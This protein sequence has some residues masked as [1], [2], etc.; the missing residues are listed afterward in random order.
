M[1]FPGTSLPGVLHTYTKYLVA[2]E[3]TKSNASPKKIQNTL[4]FIGGLMDGLFTV[5]YATP[6]AEAMPPSWSV[7]SVLLSSSYRQW[8]IASLDSD[9]SELASCVSYFRKLRPNGKIVLMGHSTGCQDVMHYLV[10]LESEDTSLEDSKNL[11]GGSCSVLARPK[12]DGGIMQASVSDRE[13]LIMLLPS[14]QYEASVKIAQVYISQNRGED[15]LPS[16]ATAGFLNVPVSARR[17]LSLA[18]PGPDHAG[19]D[20]FFSSDLPDSRIKETFG[21]MSH[22]GDVRISILMSGED[23]FV[24]KEVDKKTMVSKWEAAVKAGEGLLD[25]DSGIVEG[26]NH[27]LDG[28]PEHVTEDLVRRVIGFVERV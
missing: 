18:S 15:I 23:Q 4:I 9:V 21:K 11:T 13:A 19:E 8:G 20:D 5:P 24:P 17:W 10:S 27:N 12:I 7:V 6:L 16:W 22:G 1:A 26:A 28:V 3:P 25:E 2:F 14:R